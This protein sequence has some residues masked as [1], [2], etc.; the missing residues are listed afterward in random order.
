MLSV[1]GELLGGDR[2]GDLLLGDLR[3]SWLRDLTLTECLG[4]LDLHG[5]GLLPLLSRVREGA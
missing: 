5:R 4:D 1:G 2:R 3:W